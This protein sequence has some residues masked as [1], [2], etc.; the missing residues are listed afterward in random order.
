MKNE[1]VTGV[2][3][4]QGALTIL[5][6]DLKLDGGSYTPACLGQSY[7]DRLNEAGFKVDVK[8]VEG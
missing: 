5:E 4:A 8:T 2:F 6:D 3:L 1:P 7:L